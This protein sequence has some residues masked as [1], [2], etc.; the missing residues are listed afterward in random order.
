MFEFELGFAERE[1]IEGEKLSRVR[2]PEPVR[3]QT[4]RCT[5]ILRGTAPLCSTSFFASFCRS[6]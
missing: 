4:R 2:P 1:G 3:I 5:T 6:G